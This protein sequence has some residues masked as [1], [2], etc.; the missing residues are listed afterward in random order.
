MKRF[1]TIFA[2][3]VL[4]VTSLAGCVAENVPSLGDGQRAVCEALGALRS[5]AA[6]LSDITPET[7]VEQLR[8]VRDNV[9]RLIE[10]ARRAN[11][12]LQMQS[13]TDMVTSYDAFSQ[14]VDG[15]AGDQRVG[16]AAAALRASSGSVLSALEQ[17]LTAAQCA[18]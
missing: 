2:A 8:G 13:I 12:V 4:L 18:P 16:D 9:G 14:A 11:T 3:T 10:A 7:S 17:A 15:I 1:L 5:G 6:N